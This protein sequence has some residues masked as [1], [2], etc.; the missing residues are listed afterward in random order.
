MTSS[1]PHRC[2]RLY[3]N[4]PP[5]V[6]F[7]VGPMAGYPA[8]MNIPA[9]SL[10]RL[11]VHPSRSYS[12]HLPPSRPPLPRS[13]RPRLV[14]L[15]GLIALL[16]LS[17]CG[18]ERLDPNDLPRRSP[19]EVVTSRPPDAGSTADPV[20]QPPGSES[21]AAEPGQALRDAALAG[22]AQT[23]RAELEQGAD[24]AAADNQGRTPLQLASFDGHT[25]V[26]ELL[27]N[28]L[29][30]QDADVD[31]RD[32]FGRTALMYA[33]TAANVPTVRVLL[34]AGADPNVVDKEE[35]FTPLMFAAAEGQTEVVSVLL[36]AGADPSVTDADGETALD[37]ARS[38]GHTA[39]VE[40][41]TA[42]D[43]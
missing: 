35:N 21:P 32:G 36:D 41:L 1:A 4:S 16:V 22:D 17:G 34:D 40:R 42:E 14:G 5:N 10:D 12:D 2:R 25:D 3:G 27:L 19:E 18:G 6:K 23:V 31:Q 26:V 15:S 11:A 9:I 20:Q 37:F 39:V 30:E 38:G 7:D 8:G 28:E 43:E 13:P 24:P 29:A 33:S